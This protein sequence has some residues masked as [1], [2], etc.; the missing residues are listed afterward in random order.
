[1]G[2]SPAQLDL[3][4]LLSDLLDLLD[5]HVL[6]P[7]LR[8]EVGHTPGQGHHVALQPL[9]PLGVSLV[10]PPPGPLAAP[11]LRP[12]APLVLAVQVARPW[13]DTVNMVT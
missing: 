5:Y 6:G 13:G 3:L 8:G 4:Q 10:P 1:M 12:L 9:E 2:H 7:H 11:P